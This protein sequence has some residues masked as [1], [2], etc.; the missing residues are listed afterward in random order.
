[1]LKGEKENSTQ[2]K[3]RGKLD[4]ASGVGTSQ[5]S[6]SAGRNATGVTGWLPDLQSGGGGFES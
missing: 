4:K 1:M 5:Y 3:E 2:L 6:V